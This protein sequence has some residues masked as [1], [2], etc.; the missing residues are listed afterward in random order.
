M[1]AQLGVPLAPE[2]RDGP[3][4]VLIFLGIIINTV[5]GELRLPA[6]KLRRL[7]GAVEEWLGKK[8]CTRRELESLI[9]TLQH[10]NCCLSS[11]AL[12]YLI[13]IITFIP[14]YLDHLSFPIR[15]LF[16][17]I[18]GRLKEFV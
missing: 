16:G 12:Y 9:G 14:G 3:S 10:N 11:N 17:G 13:F 8:W 7:S 4:S 18:L 2:K 5:K 1:Y 15:F 6:D